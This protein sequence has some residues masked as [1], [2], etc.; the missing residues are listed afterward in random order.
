MK[1]ALA[2][3]SAFF[4]LVLSVVACGGGD[5]DEE[6]TVR[7]TT[8]RFA[9]TATAAPPFAFGSE[10]GARGP[11][12][13]SGPAGAAGTG[14][15]SQATAAPTPSPRPIGTPAPTATARPS[16]TAVPGLGSGNLPPDD[17]RKVI[18]TAN[19]VLEVTEV[20]PALAQIRLLAEGAG[21]FVESL[22]S[23]GSESRQSATIVV[24]VPPGQF[25]NVL[26][27]AERIGTVKS[28][29]V[30]SQDVTDQFIDLEA[31]LKALQRQEE[32]YLTLLARSQN[33]NDI[34]TLEREISRV[35][36]DIERIQGQ[37]N[38][39]S[40]RVDYSTIAFTL[41]LPQPTPS[42]TPTPTPTPLPTGNA[43]YASMVLK[44]PNVEA[45][46]ADIKNYALSVKAEVDAA[47]IVVNGDDKRADLGIRFFRAD[48]PQAVTTIESKGKA[49]S[50][51]VRDG[52]SGPGDKNISK[53]DARI[54]VRIEVAP[55]VKKSDNTGPIA[56][57]S[58]LG[59]L[60]LIAMAGVAAYGYGRGKRS[61]P[62]A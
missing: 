52:T 42:P 15:F 53:P 29:S 2:F 47:I 58:V 25:F 35:R 4:V 13:P 39:L 54:D 21:G 18:S 11:A 40:R 14:I 19:F 45:A 17:G 46:Y 24:R 6:P 41:Q 59:A 10:Q 8:S 61:K 27:Q 33:V 7:D 5:G 57:G 37:L 55:P 12:G 3:L 49:V 26:E 38:V 34:L 28:R 30:S 51:E 48:F 50:K 44:V 9:P 60:A 56:L 16:G 62:N 23:A 20:T 22:S 31:R 43:P 36:A 32:S 1:R